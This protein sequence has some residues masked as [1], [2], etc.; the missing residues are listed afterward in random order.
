MRYLQVTLGFAAAMAAAWGARAQEAP[1]PP[2][3][4]ALPEV[5]VSASRVERESMDLPVSIDIVDQ[6]TIREG[7]PQVNL[8]EV[9]GRVPGI[10][11]QNRQNFAQDLQISSRGFGARSAFGVRGVRLIADGIPATMPDGQGQAASFNLSS[12]QRIEVL[13]GPF[14]SL[15]GNA[16]G[17]VVQIFTADGPQQPTLSV[18]A[19]AGSHGTWKLGAQYGGQHGPLNLLVDTSR[20]ETDGY[21]DHSGARRD[22]ANAKLKY[23]LGSA[24]TLTFVA[25]TLDQPETADPL[26]LTAAQVAQ[27]PRQAFAGAYTFNTRKSTTQTQG[28]LTW[29]LPLSGVDAL[30]A[31]A[32]AGDRQ[33][34]QYLAIPLA[35][36]AAA[37]SS[38]GVVD[39]DRGYSGL[40]LRWTRNTQWAG[41]RFTVSAGV[42]HDRLAEQ[43]RGFV[44]NNGIA[45]A[46]KRDE[47]DEVSN[48]DVYAQ[49][50]WQATERLGVLAG[51]RHSRVRFD[52]R[53]R[54]VAPGNPDDSGAVNF[55]RTTPAA[56]ATWRITPALNA[57]VNA[58]RGFETPTFAE[59][60]YRPSGATGLNF[61]LQPSR[62]LHRELGI[63]ALTGTNG[64]LNVA[65]FRIDV[66]D[67][68]VVNS[69]TGGRTDFKNASGTRREGVEV[70]WR[71]QFAGGFETALAWTRLDARFRESFTSGTPAST[72]AAG[73][74]LPGVA[75]SLIY[76][77][78]VWRDAASGFYAAVEAR[79][80]DKVFVND[81]NSD[82]AAGYVVGN[83]RTGFQQRGKGWRVT[84]FIRVDNFTDR[85][86]VGSVIVAEANGRFFEPAPGRVFTVGVTVEVSR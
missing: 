76:G 48:T 74:R 21:R 71:Q 37:T 30:H 47:D 83:L 60:A 31:R 44:N 66:R 20:F 43:R 6:R 80:S 75:P 39:L 17:G 15:Y 28:G 50:E 62:S 1:L 41:R 85:S 4:V 59:L 14:S 72:V 3:V 24:G 55:S 70:A 27:N 46:L 19:V 35:A 18:N 23:D 49:F 29:D 11:V 53:D 2:P 79:Q 25:N 40:G 78:L 22:Q 16:A 42:D 77:E 51:L 5:T 38:G 10:A 9:L 84:E 7:N 13:R 8:S 81:Q 56:G 57:Y 36:Q 73:S 52:S 58:G 86:Y 33:V 69:S 32:Y 45:G 26:G 64:H 61:A 34:T 65:L 12:A 68:I 54:F 67:E 63:K 82:A